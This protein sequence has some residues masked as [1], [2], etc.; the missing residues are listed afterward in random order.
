MTFDFSA[1]KAYMGGL[2]G[3][4]FGALVAGFIVHASEA[5]FHLTLPSDVEGWVI[6]AIAG[7]IS[8]VGVY[9]TTNVVK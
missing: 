6:T 7:A 1:L 4:G 9:F 8:Y 3:A 2:M 5:A